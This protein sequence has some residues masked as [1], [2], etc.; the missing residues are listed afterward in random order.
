MDYLTSHELIKSTQHGFIARRSCTTNLLEFLE[1]C[2][3]ILDEGDPLDIVYLD[4]AKAF[5]K[6]PHQRLLNKMVSLGIRGDIL[7]WTENWLKNHG[8]RTVLN[9]C[10]SEWQ[11]VLSGVPQGSVL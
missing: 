8:Q 1:R 6:V 3:H 4:F 9:G 5:Y 10:F 11:D 7:R 2:T